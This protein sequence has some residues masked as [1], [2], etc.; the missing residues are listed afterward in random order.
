MHLAK[1]DLA[2]LQRIRSRL[3]QLELYG[4]ADQSAPSWL[5]ETNSARQVQNQSDLVVSL[6]RRKRQTSSA[7]EENNQQPG[8]D[9]WLLDYLTGDGQLAEP[10]EQVEEAKPMGAPQQPSAG[11]QVQQ[12]SQKCLCPPGKLNISKG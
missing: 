11:Q 7:S 1:A 5:V 6:S 8:K 4:D 3:R 9:H 12:R 2:H 10:L